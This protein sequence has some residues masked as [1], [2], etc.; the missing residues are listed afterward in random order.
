MIHLQKPHKPTS[1]LVRLNNSLEIFATL[2]GPDGVSI[3]VVFNRSCCTLEGGNYF[4]KRPGRFE[5][6]VGG[7]E[8]HFHVD[9]LCDVAARLLVDICDVTVI[10]HLGHSVATILPQAR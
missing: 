7:C 8:I 1:T 4:R 2:G 10:Q 6:K 5:L 9:C 3:A